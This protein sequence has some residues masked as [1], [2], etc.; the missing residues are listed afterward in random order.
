MLSRFGKLKGPVIVSIVAGLSYYLVPPSLYEAVAHTRIND[1]D[2]MNL[3]SKLASN[4]VK[5]APT[6]PETTFGDIWSNQSCVV[7]FFRRF[8]W[9]YCKLAAAEVSAIKPILDTNNVKLVGV[10]LEELGVQ[11]FIDEKYFKGDLYI[12]TD[13]KSYNALGFKRFGFFGLF[14]AVL[15]AAARAAQSKAKLLG[16]SGN[17]AGDG[18]QNGGA[19][20]V[21]V[22]GETL[23]HYVQEGAPDHASNLDLLKALNIDPI[24][25]PVPSA[26]SSLAANWKF[27]MPNWKT[28][29]RRIFIWPF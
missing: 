3:A 26:E 4:V 17:M 2:K 9:P 28:N 23:F 29:L 5:K 18:Y 20:V 6:G 22:N 12:D 24:P 13:K 21:G 1:A 25:D 19:L 7:V 14:P 8:G 16:M 27:Y 15:S 10:G 11:E